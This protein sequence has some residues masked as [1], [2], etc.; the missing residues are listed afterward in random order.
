MLIRNG[1]FASA[2][3]QLHVLASDQL[4]RQPFADFRVGGVVAAQDLDLHIGRQ[5]LVVFLDVEVDRLLRLITSLRDKA[6]IAADQ[7][8]FD[9][10]LRRRRRHD[11]RRQRER[12]RNRKSDGPPVCH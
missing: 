12:Q 10:R 7:P 3:Q 2:V 8:D 1:T 6:G 4:L 9:D 5:I 11:Q